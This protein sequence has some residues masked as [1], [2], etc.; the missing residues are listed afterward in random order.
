MEF[1]VIHRFSWFVKKN[2]D[3]DRRKGIMLQKY[4]SSKAKRE[5][6]KS[7]LAKYQAEEIL[8]RLHEAGGCGADKES[9]AGGWDAAIT[10]AISIVEGVTG[11]SIAEV[12]N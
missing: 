5:Y 7:N 11:V 10:E 3:K 2:F 12:L 1:T 6:Y 9:W 4:F 8:R